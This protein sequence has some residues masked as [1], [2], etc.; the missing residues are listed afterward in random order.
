MEMPSVLL[1]FAG[2]STGSIRMPAMLG[3]GVNFAVSN[4]LLYT[5]SSC[6]WFETPWQS[7]YID[8]VMT[9]MPSQFTSLTV[10]Y[11]TVY[12]DADQR[13]HQSSVSLAFVWGIH[14]DRWI[15]RTK[16]QLR[17]EYFHLMTSSWCYVTVAHF[18]TCRS[19]N[20]V[21]LR[22]VRVECPA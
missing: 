2:E 14:R 7:H 15:H 20:T 4:K 21:R 6:R 11:S 16:G 1:N 22:R 10:V 3:F 12:S 19:V 13:K 17:G 18:R 8:V 9:T 5:Q